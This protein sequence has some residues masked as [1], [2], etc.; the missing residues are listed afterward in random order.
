MSEKPPFMPP[1]D[2]VPFY[3]VLDAVEEIVDQLPDND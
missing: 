3:E 2:Y 1:L